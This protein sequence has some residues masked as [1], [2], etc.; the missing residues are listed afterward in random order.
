M[1][2]SHLPP[3]MNYSH[4]GQRIEQAWPQW[5]RLV[6]YN[7]INVLRSTPMEVLCP[8]EPI[9]KAWRHNPTPGDESL[10][11]SIKNSAKHRDWQ[12]PKDN[13]VHQD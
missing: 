13:D 11:C 9:S 8:A 1:S 3:A 4:G 6:L 5:H 7:A 10:K 2:S 12:T